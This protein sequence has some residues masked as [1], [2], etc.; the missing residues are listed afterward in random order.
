MKQNPIWIVMAAACVAVPCHA[1]NIAV[2]DPAVCEQGADVCVTI[3]MI[4]DGG[5]LP[6]VIDVPVV[7][8]S[9]DLE[10]VDP[11]I[12]QT[13]VGPEIPPTTDLEGVDPRVFW[14]TGGG[15]G[16]QAEAFRG[17][18]AASEAKLANTLVESK[19]APT[20]QK[21]TRVTTKAK[22][23]KPLA[24]AAR[25]KGKAQGFVMVHTASEKSA[26]SKVRQGKRVFLKPAKK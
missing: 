6:P 24:A 16:V 26:P 11:R 15:G 5:E 17:G 7:D 1:Q 2:I 8:I 4:P 13:G 22:K 12:F 9:G 10:G 3:P 20:K 21:S 19:L 18:A 14:A 25:S 23:A